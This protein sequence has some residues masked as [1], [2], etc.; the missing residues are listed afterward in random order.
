MFKLSAN[1]IIFSQKGSNGQDYRKCVCKIQG[2]KVLELEN[3]TLS[4]D[5]EAFLTRLLYSSAQKGHKTN[6][7]WVNGGY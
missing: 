4:A 5:R 6:A 7:K 3:A 1:D 2:N